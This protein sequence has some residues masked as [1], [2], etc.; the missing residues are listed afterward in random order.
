MVLSES[1]LFAQAIK[2]EPLDDRLRSHGCN[3]RPVRLREALEPGRP[4]ARRLFA[5]LGL[6]FHGRRWCWHRS[7]HR[8]QFPGWCRLGTFVAEI[9]AASLEQSDAESRG[10]FRAGWRFKQRSVIVVWLFRPR[11]PPRASATASDW[12]VANRQSASEE[13]RSKALFGR[14]GPDTRG[15]WVGGAFRTWRRSAGRDEDGEDVQR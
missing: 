1:Y 12:R 5:K 3:A 11:S 2:G 10:C 6:V 8:A 14:P 9:S 13:S 4:S 15:S 7:I